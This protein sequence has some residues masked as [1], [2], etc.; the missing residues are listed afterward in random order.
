MNTFP[1]FRQ[2]FRQVGLSRLRSTR[3][4]FLKS[5]FAVPYIVLFSGNQ[6]PQYFA[7]RST[8]RYG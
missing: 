5:R 6:G 4:D 8:P 3:R 1:V 2:T 7:W